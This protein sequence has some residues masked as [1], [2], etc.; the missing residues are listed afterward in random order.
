M[1]P[2]EA[3][4]AYSTDFSGDE[5]FTLRIKDLASGRTLPDEIPN[6]YYGCAWSLDG[7]A[8]FY[9]TVD[10]AWRPYRVWRHR[11][12]TA[13]ADDVVVFEEADERFWL[14]VGPDAQ[15]AVRADPH[16]EQ[17]D[18]RG[19]A[20]RRRHARAGTS[21]SSRPGGR[22]WSTTSRSPGTGC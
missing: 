11:V 3:L 17:A 1:S 13:A 9:I 7:T 8:L 16:V 21:P 6:T 14:D 22:A 12:G 19:V 18:Q 15:R 5:R 2:D 10:D 20:A 4:L